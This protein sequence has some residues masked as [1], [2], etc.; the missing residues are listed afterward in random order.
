MAFCLIFMIA[1][2]LSRPDLPSRLRAETTFVRLLDTL[3]AR[4]ERKSVQGRAAD[5][6]DL[7]VMLTGSTDV[8]PAISSGTSADVY[9]SDNKQAQI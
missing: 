5:R 8:D 9:D 4:L 6:I 1:V 2:Q 7:A 3:R